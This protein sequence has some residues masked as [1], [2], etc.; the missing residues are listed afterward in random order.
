VALSNLPRPRGNVPAGPERPFSLLTAVTV[1][2][3]VAAPAIYCA[4]WTPWVRLTL[5]SLVLIILVVV[6]LMTT[7]LVIPNML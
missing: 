1:F 3:T 2:L 4:S 5:L 7:R 6:V